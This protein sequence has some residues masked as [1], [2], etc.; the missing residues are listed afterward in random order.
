VQRRLG[1]ASF[2]LHSTPGPVTPQVPHLD[3][4]TAAALLADQTERAGHAR[5][6]AGPERWMEGVNGTAAA[7]PDPPS[8]PPTAPPAAPA[9]GS[10]GSSPA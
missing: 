2:Q 1:L 6:S 8:D 10:E 7:S 5:A 3:A 4:G 9:P